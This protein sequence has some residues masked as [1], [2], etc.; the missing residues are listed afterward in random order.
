MI[1]MSTQILENSQCQLGALT[2][3][4]VKAVSFSIAVGYCLLRRLSCIIKY[5]RDTRLTWL[6]SNVAHQ[7]NVKAFSIRG[8]SREIVRETFVFLSHLL[9]NITLSSAGSVVNITQKILLPDPTCMCVCLCC[10]F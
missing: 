10:F 1:G 4:N 2:I 9:C 8:Q 3:F 6:V 7:N 5:W